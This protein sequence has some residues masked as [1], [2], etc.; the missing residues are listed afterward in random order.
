MN[1]LSI[2]A[3]QK[4]IEKALS[5]DGKTLSAIAKSHNVGVS[6]LGKMVKEI[7]RKWYN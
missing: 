1:K 5:R 2:S 7:P 4:I 6:T 3:K